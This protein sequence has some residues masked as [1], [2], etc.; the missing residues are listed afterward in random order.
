MNIL[1]VVINTPL[2]LL[3]RK[4]IFRLSQKKTV[5]IEKNSLFFY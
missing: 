1:K 4:I 2:N 5:S 3:F